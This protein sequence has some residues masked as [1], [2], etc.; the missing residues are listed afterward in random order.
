MATLFVFL[1]AVPS[2]IGPVFFRSIRALPHKVAKFLAP[3]ALYLCLDHLRLLSWNICLLCCCSA[4]L[5]HLS[6]VCN[7]I[8]VFKIEGGIS[9][10]GLVI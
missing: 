9:L 7:P 6:P 4:L 1:L 10:V 8:A 2:S 3:P 5:E